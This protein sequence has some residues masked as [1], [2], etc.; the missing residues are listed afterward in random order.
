MER[1]PRKGSFR[2]SRPVR[3]L[4]SI[5]V[6]NEERHV[7]AVLDRVMRHAGNVLVVDDGSTDRTPEVLKQYP[8]DVIRHAVNRGYGRSIRDAFMWAAADGYDWVVTMDMDTQHEPEAIPE[9]LDAAARN[10]VDI[11][12]GSRYMGVADG[13]LN[14][15][16]PFAPP[17]DRRAINTAVTEELNDRLGGA[18]GVPLTDAFCGFK[19][20]R[21]E[22]MKSL[23]LDVDG[24]AF[25][26]QFWVQAAAKKLRVREIPVALIYNDL[27]RTFGGPLDDPTTRLAHYREVMHREI[28]RV[29][30]ELPARASAGMHA[31][32][33]CRA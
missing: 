21:V 32:C 9:F 23:N 8:V 1:T 26:M 24:Y 18:L 22:A 13:T 29:A 12:S 2:R 11:I 15:R 20:Y 6:H 27:T 7:R 31:T 14:E 33:C 28:R 10:G 3:A 17:A 4:V 5:P 16:S 30:G 19:A 25:P